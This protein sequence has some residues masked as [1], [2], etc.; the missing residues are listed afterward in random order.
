MGKQYIYQL[1]GITKKYGQRVVLDNVWLAF[2]PGAKIGVL[3]RNGSGKSTLLRIMAGI[4]RDFDGDAR[5]TEGFTVG[6]LSQEP[7]LN[8]DKD[9]WGNVEESVAK[10]RAVLARYDEI[11]ARLA[12]PLEPEEMEKLLDEQARVGA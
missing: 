12:E 7:Q 2:Y 6:Y 4:D 5:L 11:N 10:T 1:S 8:P 3:G 9:V